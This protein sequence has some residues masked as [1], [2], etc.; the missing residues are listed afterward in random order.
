MSF[1]TMR[2]AM[3]LDLPVE[4]GTGRDKIGEFWNRK[5]C[6]ATRSKAPKVPKPR[7]LGGRRTRRFRLDFPV[8]LVMLNVGGLNPHLRVGRNCAQRNFI[9]AMMMKRHIRFTWL[10]GVLATASIGLIG[11]AFATDEAATAAKEKAAATASAQEV[12]LFEGMRDG[13]LDVTII[14]KSD[15]AARVIIANKTD[16]PVSVKL[17]EAFA[18]VPVARAVRRRRRWARWRRIR[19]RWWRWRSTEWRRRIRWRWRW[20]G[21]RRWRCLQHSARRDRQDQRRHG[22][23]RP[24]PARSILLEAVQDRAGRGTCRPAGGDRIAQGLRPRRARPR[25]GP[26]GRLESQQRHELGR[27]GGEANR[28]RPQHQSLAVLQRRTNS[29]RHGLRPR[30]NAPAPKYAEAKR[31]KMPTRTTPTRSRPRTKISAKS[32]ARGTTR[33]NSRRP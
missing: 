18:A 11:S 12:G 5:S 10:S 15:R 23:P 21:W 26:G 13:R 17:P 4:T 28:H 29:R 22:L 2:T 27:A 30:S 16:Q 25:C 32:A 14:T 20:T 24:R 8:S 33:P 1:G 19:R 3:S 7:S 9:G 6:F 31:K